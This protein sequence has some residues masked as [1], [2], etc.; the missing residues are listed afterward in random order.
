MSSSLSLVALN[1]SFRH[2]AVVQDLSL[3]LAGGE[4][5]A[6]LGPSGCGKSTTLQM[7][8]GLI[9][10]DRGE[11]WLGDRCLNRIPPE[12]RGMAMV[13]QQGLLF[14]YLTVLENVAFGLRMRGESRGMREAKALAMLER[15]Q[16][17][18][19]A[20]R[21]PTQL[22]GGQAQ[23]VA[24]ARALVIEPEVLLL[25]EP[26][27]ALDASL[28]Q[29]MQD[30]ILTLQAETQVT[31]LI[32]TH[33]QAEAVAMADRIALMF[34]G[35]LH[36]LGSASDFYQTPSSEAAA[37]FFGGVNFFEA[38]ADG[39][40]LELMQGSL[41]T[42]AH[43][44][45]GRVTVT[46]RPERVQVSR[47]HPGCVNALVMRVDSLRFLGTQHR[48]TLTHASG[49]RLQAWLG[50]DPAVKVT[51]EVWVALPP[52]ALWPLPEAPVSVRPPILA[53]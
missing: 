48:L 37:R 20:H 39:H 5:L 22:S 50:I 23:R 42:C 26:L 11:V 3:K 18:S 2:L 17:G 24:L 29:E 53:A 45:Q 21:Q 52:A 44:R 16:L 7:I 14:P 25:D 35:T 32:V 49:W 36:Q 8:G 6:L 9:E 10:P 15:V 41:L 31:T 12:K 43:A 4:I 33:D 34:G 46:I 47:S 1:K 30:L 38:E 51:D 40:R 28:R 19:L 27:S 13:F